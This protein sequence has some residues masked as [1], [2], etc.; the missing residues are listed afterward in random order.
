MHG[1]APPPRGT[2]THTYT[3]THTHTQKYTHTQTYIHECTHT[4]THEVTRVAGRPGMIPG[5]CTEL[6][7]PGQKAQIMQKAVEAVMQH[8]AH[9]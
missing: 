4:D 7:F 9:D 6:L 8:T 2:H 5:V 3:H 1:H